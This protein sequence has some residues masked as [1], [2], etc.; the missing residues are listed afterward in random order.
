MKPLRTEQELKSARREL[1]DRFPFDNGA[2]EQWSYQERLVKEVLRTEDEICFDRSPERKA[3]LR[4]VRTYADALAWAN[5]SDYS[6]RQLA[7]NTG[8]SPFLSHQREAFEWTMNFARTLAD[9]GTPVLFA[10]LTN[11]LKIGDLIVCTDPN[12]PTLFEC[13]LSKAKDARDRGVVEGN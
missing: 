11:I 12:A 3:H 7:R 4:S 9:Q 6:I 10:D 5:L 13:K 2:Q 1:F 8:K